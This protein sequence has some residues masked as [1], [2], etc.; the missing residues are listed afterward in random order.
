MPVRILQITAAYI[1]GWTNFLPLIWPWQARLAVRNHRQNP[2]A[3]WCTLDVF[4]HHLQSLTQLQGHALKYHSLWLQFLMQL[5]MG[6]HAMP[7]NYGRLARPSN[8]WHLHILPVIACHVVPRPCLEH[9]L[10]RRLS[11]WLG[12]RP[13]I[14]TTR[15]IFN[16]QKQGRKAGS[17]LGV[18]MGDAGLPI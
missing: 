3:D 12:Q 8:A 17:Q 9:W 4:C 10:H 7:P 14:G 13:H 11:Q 5:G 16:H 6:G 15:H 18:M 2:S 1:N